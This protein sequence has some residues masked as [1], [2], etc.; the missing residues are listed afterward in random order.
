M[1]LARPKGLH[2]LAFADHALPLLGF[3]FSVG[4]LFTRR[5]LIHRLQI[6]RHP[7][8]HVFL[9]L[10]LLYSLSLCRFAVVN[11]FDV[12]YLSISGGSADGGATGGTS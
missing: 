3:S 8:S 12:R 6:A 5:P 7:L 2:G 10:L 4:V 9:D 1:V 11:N